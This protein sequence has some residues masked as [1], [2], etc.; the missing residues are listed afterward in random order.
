MPCCRYCGEYIY[1]PPEVEEGIISLDRYI[2]RG[3]EC[4]YCNA[5]LEYGDLISEFEY[6]LRNLVGDETAEKVYEWVGDWEYG[7]ELVEDILKAA[8]Q[9][10]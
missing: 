10:D 9:E 8:R 3:I 2:D 4:S 7:L 1:L 6:A 5:I